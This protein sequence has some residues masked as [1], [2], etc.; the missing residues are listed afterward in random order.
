MKSQRN[1]LALWSI[2]GL[3]AFLI[4]ACGGDESVPTDKHSGA[5]GHPGSESHPSAYT[6]PHT[7]SGAHANAH[8]D[9]DCHSPSGTQAKFFLWC[10]PRWRLSR[11]P[12]GPG[13]LFWLKM[14]T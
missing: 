13:P 10:R 4:A 2:L 5:H 12:L 6:D 8:C 14:V 11:L 9:T 7:Q 1:V 3:L